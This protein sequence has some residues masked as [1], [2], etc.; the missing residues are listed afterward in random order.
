MYLY[1]PKEESDD[2]D[3][4]WFYQIME[5]AYDCI[6]NNDIWFDADC[7]MAIGKKNEAYKCWLG[8]PTRA[9]HTHYEQPRSK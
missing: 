8:R 4:D 5:G 2:D 3:K 6:S 1:T 9:R 7:E